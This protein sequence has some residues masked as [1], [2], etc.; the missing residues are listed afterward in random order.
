MTEE[1]TF[2]YFLEFQIL[3]CFYQLIKMTNKAAPLIFL[4]ILNLYMLCQRPIN[5]KVIHAHGNR[6]CLDK[7]HSCSSLKFL[8]LCSIIFIREQFMV[9]LILIHCQTANFVEKSR[10]NFRLFLHWWRVHSHNI[11]LHRFL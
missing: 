3:Y 10:I 2:I 8:Y 5:F 6:G 4:I 11:N 1:S 9:F 7:I